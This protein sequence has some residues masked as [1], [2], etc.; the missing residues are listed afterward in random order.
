M[1]SKGAAATQ[2]HTVMWQSLTFSSGQQVSWTTL[3]APIDSL[4]ACL[5][6]FT[7]SERA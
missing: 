1:A 5:S 7:G 6:K 4:K 2:R 3:Q